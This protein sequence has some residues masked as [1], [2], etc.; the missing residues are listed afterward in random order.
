MEKK[1]LERSRSVFGR[2]YCNIKR[3]WIKFC[4]RVRKS[5]G[6]WHPVV[7][8]V[9]PGVSKMTGPGVAMKQ[10]QQ[11]LCLDMCC[12]GMMHCAKGSH[13][14]THNLCWSL[15]QHFGNRWLHSEEVEVSAHEWFWMQEPNLYLDR[16]F[17]LVARWDKCVSVF[18]NWGKK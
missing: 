6:I 4:K 11:L 8:W 9:V 18:E 3:V 2:F 10:V 14:T 12:V 7:G 1:I 5:S 15:K 13:F 16:V 17:K